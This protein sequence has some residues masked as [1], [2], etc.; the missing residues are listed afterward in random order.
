MKSRRIWELIDAAMSM[1]TRGP[2]LEL[3]LAIENTRYH[4]RETLTKARKALAGHGISPKDREEWT[5]GPGET[6]V[7]LYDGERSCAAPLI[8]ERRAQLGLV[9]EGLDSGAREQSRVALEGLGRTL[10]SKFKGIP[11]AFSQGHS[12]RCLLPHENVRIDGASLGLSVCIAALSRYTGI[13]PHSHVAGTAAIDAEGNLLPVK[14]LAEKALAAQKAFPKIAAIVVA[15]DQTID[16]EPPIPVLRCRSL[17]EATPAFGLDITSTALGTSVPLSEVRVRLRSFEDLTASS[18]ATWHHHYELARV[19]AADVRLSR[20]ERAMA[21]M[22]AALF[23]THAA[24]SAEAIQII[25]SLTNEEAEQLPPRARVWRQLIATT[26]LIDEDPSRAAEVAATLVADADASLVAGDR[27]DLLGRAYGTFGRAL[28]HCGRLEEATRWLKRGVEHHV[29]YATELPEQEAQSRTYLAICCRLAGNAAAAL[30]ECETASHV[31]QRSSNEE[32]IVHGRRFVFLEW[33]R[34]LI[35][36]DRPSEAILKLQQ[37]VQERDSDHPWISALGSL[38]VAHRD[39]ADF[40]GAEAYLRR[41]LSVAHDVGVQPIIRR[42][43]ASAAVGLW[44]TGNSA[45]PLVEMER[46]QRLLLQSPDQ[47][48]ALAPY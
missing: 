3:L 8:V 13:P 40:V 18:L 48:A 46:A 7:L 33:G 29:L 4:D 36:L 37:C 11:G 26:A 1:D 42:I 20:K 47:H 43:A 2:A 41:C 21:L 28:M 44:S 15:A 38:G 34:C 23:A 16:D 32:A 27:F 17:A 35:A 22:W 24:M 25:D 14:R 10:H 5:P 45:I 31:L 19:V 12:V 39:A 9:T 6:Y 30:T